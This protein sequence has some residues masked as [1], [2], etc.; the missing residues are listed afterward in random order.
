MLSILEL[1]GSHTMTKF[2]LTTAERSLYKTYSKLN[3]PRHTSYPSVPHWK[4]DGDKNL[5]TQRLMQLAQSDTEVS[6][7]V[8]VPFCEKLCHYCGCNKLI[9]SKN[10]SE[11]EQFAKRYLN[12][13]EKELELLAQANKW[14]TKQLHFGG[15][16]PT[17]FSPQDFVRLWDLLLEK[18]EILP[19]AE[20]SIEL[21]PRVTSLAHLKTLKDLGF[22]RISLGIQDFDP[23]VQDAIERHQSFDSVKKFVESCRKE[24]FSN[25]NFDLIYGLPKQT[26]KSMTETLAKVIELNPNRIAF[27][28]L[29]L[30]PEIF[31]WQ[32]TFKEADIPDDDS[33]LGFMLLA[34][35]VFNKNGYEFIG[36]DHFS[37]KT[38][39]LNHALQ[40]GTLRRS[41]QGMTT[42][43]ELPVIGIGPSA[44]SSL[45]DLYWQNETQF[46][47]WLKNMTEQLPISRTCE[48][49]NEDTICR[50][51]INQLY[52]YREISKDEFYKKFLI[53]FD[54]FFADRLSELKDLEQEGLISITHNKIALPSLAS[55]LLVRVVASAFDK[56]LPANAWRVGLSQGQASRVG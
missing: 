2:E 5:V 15:G 50:W 24:G 27:Y 21:D 19:D 39:A 44:I 26:Y 56:W 53:Q 28:R 41:F 25:I 51:T 6:W 45:N 35:N 36:L 55:W 34:L 18:I 12:G 31:K 9:I 29:A 30:L 11:S 33:T 8:H 1:F 13:I 37:K 20:I 38:E 22:N 49:T 14:K 10:H 52:C 32:R 43:D 4:T 54:V 42:G 16:T 23:L 40:N 48:L 47:S 17:W 46:Q 7:Y 3:L